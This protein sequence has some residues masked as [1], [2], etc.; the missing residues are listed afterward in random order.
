M[1]SFQ[2]PLTGERPLDSVAGSYTQKDEG[3]LFK[4]NRWTACWSP[5]LVSDILYWANHG[6]LVKHWGSREVYRPLE[7]YADNPSYYC[8]WTAMSRD[9][10][11]ICGPVCV[12][13]YVRNLRLPHITCAPSRQ[14]DRSGMCREL[15]NYGWRAGRVFWFLI[16]TTVYFTATPCGERH[17][18]VCLVINLQRLSSSTFSTP[19]FFCFF[20][21]FIAATLSH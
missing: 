14:I 5:W 12:R 2:K 4:G 7:A 1:L 11:L 16:T 21:S 8:N 10:F 19:S 17:R 13:V 9:P 3:S 20:F 6:R 18:E 15:V